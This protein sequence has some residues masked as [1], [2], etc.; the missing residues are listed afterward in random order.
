MRL[1]IGGTRAFDE[2]A[3]EHVRREIELLALGRS[4][5]VILSRRELDYIQAASE[6][7]GFVVEW[8]EGGLENHWQASTDDAEAL[9]EFFVAYLQGGDFKSHFPFE[10][11][12]L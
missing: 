4:E 10:K 3:E 6:E 12:E 8:Q 7:A 5:F 2:P 1:E 11:L 9:A